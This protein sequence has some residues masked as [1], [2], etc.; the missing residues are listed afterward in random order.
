MK[1]RTTKALKCAF[2]C[3]VVYILPTLLFASLNFQR[4]DQ[5][6]ALIHFRQSEKSF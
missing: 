5:T 2:M 6:S 4:A 1:L 3:F